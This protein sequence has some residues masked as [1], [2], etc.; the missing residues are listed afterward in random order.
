MCRLM[1]G[2]SI[3]EETAGAPRCAW[4][5]PQWIRNGVP[6][7]ERLFDTGRVF[8]VTRCPFAAPRPRRDKQFRVGKGVPY[9]YSAGAALPTRGAIFAKA[10]CRRE[11]K[12]FPCRFSGRACKAQE[13]LKNR[14]EMS[15]QQRFQ[16][17]RALRASFQARVSE[18]KSAW[19]I[20]SAEIPGQ[21][22]AVSVNRIE[23]SAKQR[24]QS[25]IPLAQPA[26]PSGK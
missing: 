9:V 11:Q 5:A 18:R 19:N 26:C 20:R 21:A 3:P 23:M 10:A 13:N 25:I 1:K 6:I 16:S 22:N 2:S 24:F 17:K 8:P 12:W 4:G 7:D 14:I 15:A